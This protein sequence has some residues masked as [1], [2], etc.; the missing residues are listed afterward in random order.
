MRAITTYDPTLYDH[1]YYQRLAAWSRSRKYSLELQ[2]LIS[3]LRLREN[4]TLLDVGCGI[5]EAMRYVTRKYGCQVFGIDFPPAWMAPP[6]LH[7]L[8]RGDAAGLPF[9]DATFSKVLLIHVIGH[10]PSSAAVLREIRRVLKPQGICGILTPN[11][12]FVY[13]YRLLNELRIVAHRPDPTVVR[14]FSRQQLA[15]IVQAAGFHKYTVCYLGNF[16]FSGQKLAHSF[17]GLLDP[18][19]E[20][21]LCVAEKD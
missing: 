20:R 17:S 1:Q 7:C 9:S 5:G 19:R 6:N 18:L 3:Q 10:V 11:R 8:V 2:Q 12:F 4:D 14:L 13:F 21:I 15:R 16:P